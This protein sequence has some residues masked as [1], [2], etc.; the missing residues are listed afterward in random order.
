M[1]DGGREALA[2]VPFASHRAPPLDEQPCSPVRI[3]LALLR[4]QCLPAGTCEVAPARDRQQRGRE[5]SR[6]RRLA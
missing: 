3:I 2:A 6:R 1:G 4:A 5:C